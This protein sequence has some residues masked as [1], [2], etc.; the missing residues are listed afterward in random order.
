MNK[1]DLVSMK[2]CATDIELWSLGKRDIT[3]ANISVG[4]IKKNE[5]D[6][7][8]LQEGDAEGGI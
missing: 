3:L 2:L 8:L 1:E 5:L 7:S 6:I 4:I